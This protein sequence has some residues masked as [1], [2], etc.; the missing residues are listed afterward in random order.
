MILTLLNSLFIFVIFLIVVLVFL[1][2]GKGDMGLGSMGGGSQ[3]LFGG[4]G[5]QNFF[6][7]FTWILGVCFMVGALTLTVLTMKSLE[8]SRISAEN[9]SVL[10]QPVN[11]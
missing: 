11:R 9:K 10:P 7:K 6:E 2:K 1:Q 8:T 4:G 5:G 3:A